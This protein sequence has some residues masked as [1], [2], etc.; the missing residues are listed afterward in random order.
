VSYLWSQ[1][2]GPSTATIGTAGQASTLVSGLVQGVYTFQLTVTDNSGIK[3]TDVV[4]VTVNAAAPVPGPPSANAGADQTITLP[5]SS[6]TLSGSGSEANGTIVSYQWTQTSGPSTATIGTAG[7]ASTAVSGLVQGVYVFQLTVTD[8][9]GVTATDVVKVTVNPAAAHVPPVAVAG[10]DQTV[11]LPV[12]FVSLDG[13]GSYDTDGTIVSYDWVQISGKGGVTITNSTT[14]KPDLYGLQAGTYV[15][16]LTVTDNTGATAS[17]QVTI[18]VN[19]TASTGPVAIAGSDTTI[20][21][22]SST[23]VLNGSQSYSSNGTI[24]SYA[25]SQ[26]SGPSNATIATDNAAASTVSQLALGV[27]VFQLTVTDNLGNVDSSTVTVTVLN[28]ERTSKDQFQIYPNPVVGGTI[29]VNGINNYTG[30]VMVKLH[31]MRGRIIMN[32]EFDKSG[33][34]VQQTIPLPANLARG[35][36]VLS[37][38][39]DGQ[40][41]PYVYEIVKQ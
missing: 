20:A 17:A 18:T 15:F 26:V 5:V 29:T 4:K 11:T 30:P 27:Y 25:W 10:P 28:S 8:N 7:Q 31:D 1:L 24:V 37:I 9:S 35:V 16:Q 19:G 2:S 6:T 39:F 38:H 21:Y 36:Y 32:Y 33:N 40:S 34:S 22:P 14:A 3:A 12:S 23:A 41:V 13:S